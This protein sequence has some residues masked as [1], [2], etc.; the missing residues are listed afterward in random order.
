MELVKLA[1]EDMHVH[2]YLDSS[3]VIFYFEEFT[4]EGGFVGKGNSIIKNVRKSIDKKGTD[5]WHHKE[6][7]I[8]AVAHSIATEMNNNKVQGKVCWIPIPPSKIRTDPLFDDRTYR[9]LA[10][11]I[12]ASTT[13]K[14][15]VHDVL[16]QKSNR[17]SFSSTVDK[18]IVSELASNYLM[19]D[20][21]NYLPEKDTIIIFDDL[22]TTGCHFKAVEQVVLSRYP[23]ANVIG[24]FVARRVIAKEDITSIMLNGEVF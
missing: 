10:F 23:N 16:Y 12:A 9:M 4:S 5:E 14:H 24:V 17:E 7:A 20:M 6:R 2:S 22:L 11:A 15:F 8:V 19:N 13:R 1:A 3:D 21:P 18:R